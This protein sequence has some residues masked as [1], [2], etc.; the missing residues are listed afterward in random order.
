MN[1]HGSLLVIALVATCCRLGWA[2]EATIPFPNALRSAD[3]SVDRL[4]D[5][6]SKSLLLGN[7]DINALLYSEGG[8]LKLML[9][10]NDV[11]DAR[12]DAKLDPPL[13]TLELIERLVGQ[14]G[15]RYGGSSTILEE[16][17]G[18][19]GSQDSYHAHPYPCPRP[20]GRLVLSNQ[21]EKPVWRQIRAQGS[22]NAWQYRDGSAVMSIEG[23]PESSNG[24]AFEPLRLSTEKYDRL[25]I[26]VS[27]SE[28]AQYY[29]DLMD[30]DDKVLFKSGW[31][32]TP[33]EP[34]TL[35][36]QLPSGKQIERLILYTWTE[37]GQRAEN[38]FGRVAFEGPSGTYAVELRELVAPTSPAS[39]D[40]FHAVARVAGTVDGVPKTE[41][42]ALADR[43]VFLIQSPVDAA[44]VAIKSA[45]IPEA[46]SGEDDGTLWIEQQIPGDPDWP[47]MRFAVAVASK[48]EWK[49]SSGTATTRPSCS[50]WL[51]RG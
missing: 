26:T 42:R 19:H 37:D 33:A 4:D 6:L 15:P 50:R 1:R 51:V 24:Y 48:D 32:E 47:G 30:G 34:K 44:L 27:G 20:C 28:N 29:V 9:T 18:N 35:T 23:R 43:N 46:A 2:Q 25:A 3:I 36:F 13:P 21:A 49:D 12:L 7:G 41:M 17:W 14:E 8:Q 31:T 10:K 38:R 16:G 39:L 40:L 22:H 45:D 5:V 11:W